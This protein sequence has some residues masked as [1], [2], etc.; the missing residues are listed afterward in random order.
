MDSSALGFVTDALGTVLNI[1]RNLNLSAVQDLSVHGNRT[2]IA[3]RTRTGVRHI[4][5]CAADGRQRHT[6][7][8]MTWSRDQG[9][10]T[11]EI[12]IDG[13]IRLGVLVGIHEHR[14]HFRTLQATS[15]H[16]I[17][18]HRLG[19]FHDGRQGITFDGH[20][21]E[22]GLL[23]EREFT[24]SWAA[25]FHHLACER[26]PLLAFLG[27]MQDD[28]FRSA[29][30]L[31]LSCEPDSNG[32]WHAAGNFIVF[33]DAGDLRIADSIGEAVQG[34]GGTCVGIGANDH[35]PGQRDFL[36]HDGV[37]NPGASARRIRVELNTE[38]LGDPALALA[39]IFDSSESFA[40]DP[41]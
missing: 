38:L 19:W 16:E 28:I 6:V 7:S 3:G 41:G 23:F 36:A 15:F 30:R 17:S 21:G 13:V 5:T 8:G 35:L 12:E 33:P 29:R 18:D 2:D 39:K 9:L 27:E 40:G 24:E 11:G 14:L 1:R 25:E 22:N 20:V 31:Q 37:A 4:Q 34:S 26:S 10:N 32:S